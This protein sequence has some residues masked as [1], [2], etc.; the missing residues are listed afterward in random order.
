MK[1]KK[2]RLKKPI[3]DALEKIGEAL[4]YGAFIWMFIRTAL[5][6]MGFDF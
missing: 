4:F 6:I 3:R 1:Q 2:L 5:F